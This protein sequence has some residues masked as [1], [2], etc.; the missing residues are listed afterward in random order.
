M[1]QPSKTLLQ[2]ISARFIHTAPAEQL[3]WVAAADCAALGP[4][5]PPRPRA[6]ATT[7]PGPA[8]EPALPA[9]DRMST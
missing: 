3:E 1:Q 9:A 5:L 7:P 6:R 2:D 8:A 4:P